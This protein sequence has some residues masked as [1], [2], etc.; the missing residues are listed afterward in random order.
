MSNDEAEVQA[1]RLTSVTEAS[2]RKDM[3]RGGFIFLKSMVRLCLPRLFVLPRF[4]CVLPREF[5][6]RCHQGTHDPKVKRL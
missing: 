2:A 1:W 3:A 4:R 5:E 6:R